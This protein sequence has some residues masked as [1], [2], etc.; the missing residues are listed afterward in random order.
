MSLPFIMH[1]RVDK[2]DLEN[3]VIDS[4][5]DTDKDEVNQ[6]SRKEYICHF[7]FAFQNAKIYARLGRIGKTI[8]S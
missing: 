6:N 4:K 5:S 2:M 1:C 8:S 3:N 7:R